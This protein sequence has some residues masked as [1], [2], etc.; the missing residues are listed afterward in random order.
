MATELELFV[1]STMV[2]LAS[3]L[4]PDEEEEEEEEELL[5]ENE[6]VTWPAPAIGSSGVVGGF[7]L[8]FGA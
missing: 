7:W 4:E 8:S 1:A 2:K 6:L 3:G 5:L